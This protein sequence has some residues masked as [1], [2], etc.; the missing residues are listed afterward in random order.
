MFSAHVCSE[1]RK[2]RQP[3]PP[4]K[5]KQN[6]FIRS[7]TRTYNIPASHESSAGTKLYQR[8]CVPALCVCVCVFLF[9]NAIRP[10]T[11][12]AGDPLRD[13]VRPD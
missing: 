11:A 6:T 8:Q 5:R 1:A 7:Y 12:M 4:A 10:I 13:V 3:E 2:W 9:S